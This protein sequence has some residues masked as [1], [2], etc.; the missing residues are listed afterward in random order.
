MS[1]TKG[2]SNMS[3]YIATKKGLETLLERYLEAGVTDQTKDVTNGYEAKWIS[4]IKECI[5]SFKT[6][7]P[8]AMDEVDY[9]NTPANLRTLWRG[10]K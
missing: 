6:Y 5:D 10:L 2:A 7:E 3:K 8:I 4:A 9:E 1:M